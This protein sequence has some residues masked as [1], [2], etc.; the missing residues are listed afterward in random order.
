MP[1]QV[2]FPKACR[3]WS[4]PET[5]SLGSQE[6]YSTSNERGPEG[7]PVNNTIIK[8]PG[9]LLESSWWQQWYY[10]DDMVIKIND[11]DC[12]IIN[13]VH[14]LVCC[15]Y[16]MQDFKDLFFVIHELMTGKYFQFKSDLSPI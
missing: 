14:V 4:Y 7:N 13:P 9:I 6:G 5:Q 15:V 1:V 10:Y 11:D 2:S 16:K 3:N 8:D 12:F